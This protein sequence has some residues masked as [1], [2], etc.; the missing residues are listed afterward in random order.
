MRDPVRVAIV[1]FGA[2]VMA[3]AA[4]VSRLFLYTAILAVFL[5]AALAHHA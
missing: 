5:G 1:V 3:A 4:I 2:S